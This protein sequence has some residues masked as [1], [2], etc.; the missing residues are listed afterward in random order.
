M[1]KPKL[2]M[3]MPA[4]EYLTLLLGYIP[5]FS[6][7]KGDVMR[8]GAA[9]L[10]L[11]LTTF[12]LLLNLALTSTAFAARE[13]GAFPDKFMFRLASYSVDE[14]DTDIAVFSDDRIGAGF[15]FADDLGGD[16]R[17]TI[18]RIDIYY[19][20]NQR[21]RIDFTNFKIERD[22][23]QLL[24]VDIEVEDQ[25]YAIGD[26]VVSDISYELLKIGYAYSFYHSDAVELSFTAGLNITSYEFN[27]ELADSSQADSSKA[28]APLPMI[29]LRMSYAINPR[30][31]IHYLTE[32]FFIE[33]GDELKGSFL[34]YELDLQ[35]KIGKS[36]ILGVSLT[37]LSIDLTAND[38]E[39]RGRI[40]DSHRGLSL[41]VSYY[42]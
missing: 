31:S 15:S 41:F 21:H 8:H 19:R 7:Q 9:R 26:T 13:E 39:W 12:V 16:T 20:Y 6:V 30:W 17:V 5:V 10:I 37:R 14:A 23:R 24:K 42:L 36:F 4:Q 38:D 35:Y 40:S 18:P 29:G 28:S 1:K 3:F 11:S 32:S 2:C 33:L 25:T 27:F 34:T 22:G